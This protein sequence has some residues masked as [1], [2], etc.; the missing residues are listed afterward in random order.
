M[1]GPPTETLVFGYLQHQAEPERPTSAREVVERVLTFALL[2]QV[3]V[4]VAALI[5]LAM[6]W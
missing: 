1:I 5:R 2:V 4:L 6:L 3:I